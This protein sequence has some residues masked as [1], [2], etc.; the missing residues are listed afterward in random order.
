[1][2]ASLSRVR[3][4]RQVR[5]APAARRRRA[6]AWFRP[7]RTS[8]TVDRSRETSSTRTF[9]T[10]RIRNCCGSFNSFRRRTE[11]SDRSTR[12]RRRHSEWAE[13]GKR[14]RIAEWCRKKK[15]CFESI[16]LFSFRMSFIISTDYVPSFLLTNKNVQKEKR[17][18]KNDFAKKKL[19]NKSETKK[20]K[21][22]FFG[23]L[24]R[25]IKRT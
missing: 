23:P 11:S 7:T 24:N 6:A 12:R 2:P 14:N 17:K 1:M 9:P 8:W 25:K 15:N 16:F 10:P 20:N 18:K 4:A 22:V 5:V 21:K 19:F 13:T 3:A